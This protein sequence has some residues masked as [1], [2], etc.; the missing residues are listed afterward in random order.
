MSDSNEYHIYD[1]YIGLPYGLRLT[2]TYN[3][4]VPVE[5]VSFNATLLDDKVQLNWTTATETNNS[6]LRFFAKQSE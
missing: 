3:N 2:V 4:V 5:L 6:G 1:P